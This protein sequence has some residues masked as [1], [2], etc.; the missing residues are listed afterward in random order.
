M[1]KCI[2]EERGK[3]SKSGFQYSEHDAILRQANKN[4]INASE[5]DDGDLKLKTFLMSSGRGLIGS[6]MTSSGTKN[7]GS[8]N[9][10]NLLANSPLPPEGDFF[11]QK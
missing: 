9:G 2:S 1:G 11:T 8:E 3:D 4:S 7:I 6:M 10:M 5:T